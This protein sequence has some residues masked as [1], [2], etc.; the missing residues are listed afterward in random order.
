MP[1]DD[2]RNWQTLEYLVRYKGIS[3]LHVEWVSA[4]FMREQVRCS[5]LYGGSTAGTIRVRT[6]MLTALVRFVTLQGTWGVIRARKHIATDLGRRQLDEEEE[7]MEA[8][9]EPLPVEAF[10]DEDLVTVDK[11]IASRD[12]DIE[13]LPPPAAQQTPAGEGVTAVAA[14]SAASQVQQQQ[15]QPRRMYLVKWRGLP[16]SESTWEWAADI[17]DVRW[18]WHSS[19]YHAAMLPLPPIRSAGYEDCGIRAL[20]RPPRVVHACGAPPESPRCPTAA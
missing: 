17:K 18:K 4:A 6:H 14:I 2:R 9:R 11:V 8:G 10:F 19:L 20:Q 3:F 15:Q 13:A 12:E 7:R 1:I 16:Y 5:R